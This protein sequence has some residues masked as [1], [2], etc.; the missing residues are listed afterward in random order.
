[1]IVGVGALS[2]PKVFSDAGVILG[3]I[4]LVVLAFMSYVASTY[5]VEAM[6]AANAYVRHLMRKK[7]GVVKAQ[8]PGIQIPQDYVIVSHGGNTTDF[9][10]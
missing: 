5:M 7:Q 8:T 10:S 9:V 4:L 1:M 2:L 3:T 6:A